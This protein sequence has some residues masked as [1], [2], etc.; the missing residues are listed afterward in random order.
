MAGFSAQWYLGDKPA[1]FGMTSDDEVT[2]EGNTL[3]LPVKVWV[4]VPDSYG[5][6]KYGLPYVRWKPSVQL[7]VNEIWLGTPA[8]WEVGGDTGKVTCEDGKKEFNWVLK[9]DIPA[10]LL[11]PEND[12]TLEVHGW[13][14][15]DYWVSGACD[16]NYGS[17]DVEHKWGSFSIVARW[18]TKLVIETTPA[19]A[20]VYLDDIFVGTT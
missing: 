20:K 17:G 1:R 8:S 2:L 13:L 16:R 4:Q 18:E 5:C 19:G 7:C 9:K 14:Y 11:K 10:D 12:I 15:F 3:R 6:C